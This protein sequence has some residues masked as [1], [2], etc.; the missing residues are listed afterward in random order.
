[1]SF[2]SACPCLGP[3]AKLVR[4][5][6]GGSFDRFSSVA[7]VGRRTTSRY[8]V[9]R[10]YARRSSVWRVA[11]VSTADERP[12]TPPLRA[13]RVD[14]QAQLADQLGGEQPVARMQPAHANVA[15]QL[16]EPIGTE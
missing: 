7:R 11:C 13:V 1:M 6:S 10:S 4:M 2:A 12:S 14:A 16:L 9:P 8:Y 15:E 5:S 3:P